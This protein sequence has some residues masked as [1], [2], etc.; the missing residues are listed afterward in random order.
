[1]KVLLLTTHFVDGNKRTGFAAMVGLL[2]EFS[3]Q[4]TAN[5]EDAYQTMITVSTGA[6]GIEGLRDW[7]REHSK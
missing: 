5:Q 7:L 6:L 1:M 2:M 3:L 4:L